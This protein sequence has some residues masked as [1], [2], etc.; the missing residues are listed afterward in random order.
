MKVGDIMY[1]VDKRALKFNA[2]KN[3]DTFMRDGALYLKIEYA[4][5]INALNLSDDGCSSDYIK[6][7]DIVTPVRC[8]ITID[9]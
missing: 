6:A 8:T 7:D 1:I 4:N 5:N 3:G 2:L 9:G